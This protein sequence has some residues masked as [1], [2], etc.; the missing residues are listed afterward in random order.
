MKRAMIFVFLAL[1]SYFQ[2]NAQ[3]ISKWETIFYGKELAKKYGLYNFEPSNLVVYN[4]NY[5]SF[6]SSPVGYPS[7][8]TYPSHLAVFI[9]G[10]DTNLLELKTNDAFTEF[11][12]KNINYIDSTTIFCLVD[13]SYFAYT[14]GI[15][16]FR[17][18]ISFV[19][20]STDGGKNWT[21]YPTQQ[22][23]LL[24]KRPSLFLKM[25]NSMNGI[26]VQLPD[27]LEDYDRILLTTDGWKTYKEIKTNKFYLSISG[28]Y[29]P[30]TIAVFTNTREFWFSK[31]NGATWDTL[32]FPDFTK[33][34]RRVYFV[35]DTL[36]YFSG[37]NKTT[38]SKVLLK[39]SN[40]GAQWDTILTLKSVD[41]TDTFGIQLIPPF[42]EKHITTIID[43]KYAYTENNGKSW[44]YIT[45]QK[46]DGN[47]FIELVVLLVYYDGEI[48]Y[49]LSSLPDVLSFLT[50]EMYTGDTILSPPK[51]IEPKGYYN[52]PLDFT[53]KW[54]KVEGAETY[55]LQIAEGP[56]VDFTDPTMPL[57]SFE[58]DLILDT[59]LTDTTYKLEATKYYRTYY[60]R[61]LAQNK[62]F[63]SP[64][65]AKYFVTVENPN[66]VVE[67]DKSFSKSIIIQKHSKN[68]INEIILENFG[69][70]SLFNLLGLKVCNNCNYLDIQALPTGVYF[71]KFNKNIIKIILID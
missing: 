68:I 50:V 54:S 4:R 28:Y 41:L 13:S 63:T 55:R 21:I 58:T 34:S 23:L 46:Y 6:L 3:M 61:I 47:S 42:D 18:Y 15:N 25:A 1:S 8:L 49:G 16:I 27:T 11:I 20:K 31:D 51:F 64:W 39:T 60:C 62:N 26:L 17:R 67:P 56:G 14:D 35:N 43:R 71:L 44:K 70:F 10:K 2:I 45:S 29:S 65:I 40:K 37:Y 48:G 5:F 36:W 32:S 24:R 59:T 69:R 30:P 12:I 9:S 19:Y 33:A 66:S 7:Y 52:I 38:N 57:P 53:I 22:N